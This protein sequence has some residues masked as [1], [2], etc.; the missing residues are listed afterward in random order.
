M[1]ETTTRDR[2]AATVVD[3]WLDYIVAHSDLPGLQICIR[4][5]GE[6]VLEAAYGKANIEAGIDMTPRH[7]GHAASQSKM[8]TACAILMLM[9]EGTLRLDQAI[10]NFLPELRDHP[11]ERMVGVT[12]RDLLTHRSGLFRDGT[13]CPWWI[14]DAAFPSRDAVLAGILK[15]P[16][17]YPPDTVTKYSN[18]DYA[19]L[20]IIIERASS[21]PFDRFI[22]ERIIVKLPGAQIA[23]DY[24][25]ATSFDLMTGYSRPDRNNHRAALKHMAANALAPAVGIHGDTASLSGF[26][27]HL[28]FTDAF[29]PETVRQEIL[30]TNWP[31]MEH[32]TYRY[33][34]GMLHSSN[35]SHQFIGHPGD[36][37]G[38]S[39][40]TTHV[41]DTPYIVSMTANML[42]PVVARADSIARIFHLIH[43]T[44]EDGDL[45]SA[46]ATPFLVNEEIASLFIVSDRI[47]L[48][49]RA[50]TPDPAPYPAPLIRQA[51][52]S[53]IPDKEMGLGS[54]GEPVV[55]IRDAGG[56]IVEV[57]YAGYRRYREDLYEPL[58]QGLLA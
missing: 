24:R 17:F 51:D 40:I 28:L 3:R 10:T 45:A 25:D 26:L 43:R 27:H 57:N 4:R 56:E 34:L 52:G 42:Y 39:S 33:G 49:F 6:I 19:L 32:L 5:D 12:I 7:V 8:F 14:Q 18:Y 38:F 15:T 53:Y 9:A 48:Q 2:L 58:R 21:L 44:L 46:V 36:I 31:V 47:A 54:P 35:D 37:A 50:D 20:G 41:Q 55:F 13:D 22:D 29:L 1:S 11:D 23:T 30:H 16:L